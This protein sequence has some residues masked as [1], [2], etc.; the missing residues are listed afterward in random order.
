M[1]RTPMHYTAI[2]RKNYIQPNPLTA[3]SSTHSP[4]QAQA[5]PRSN[6]YPPDSPDKQPLPQYPPA[7]PTSYSDSPPPMLSSRPASQ[8]TQTP[9]S[10]GRIRAQARYKGYAEDQV[11]ERGSGLDG[12][13]RLWRRSS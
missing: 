3:Y 4:H 6:D 10:T 7:Y 1:G 5:S 9:F 11:R 8:S 2:T 12:A 13:R